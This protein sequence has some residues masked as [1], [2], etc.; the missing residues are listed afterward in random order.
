[1]ERK[2]INL[3]IIG[4]AVLLMAIA[5][6]ILSFMGKKSVTDLN[7]YGVFSLYASDN[8][9]NDSITNRVE[10]YICNGDFDLDKL[11]ELCKKKK[12]LYKNS[13]TFSGYYLVVFNDAN[14]V[15]QSKYPISA[16]YGGELDKLRNILA[17]YTLG[18]TRRN[19]SQLNY[20][21]KNA[22]DSVAKRIEIK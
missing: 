11:I 1:M 10:Y 16:M 4:V 9:R 6:P 8:E 22:A 20:Y 17:F 12:K 2:K 15:I 3:I 5:F 13:T 14:N 18:G 19:F 7:N 21:E